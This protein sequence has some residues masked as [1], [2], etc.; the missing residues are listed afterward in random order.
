[1][2]N[3]NT[4]QIF[5]STGGDVV[6]DFPKSGLYKLNIVTN[7]QFKFNSKV[8]VPND[9]EAKK[10]ISVTQ[11]GDV[12]WSPDL[13][14]MFWYCSNLNIGATDIPNF[15]NV[16][17]MSSMFA[18]CSNLKTI[19]YINNWNVGNVTNMSYMFFKNSLFDESLSNWNVG[20]VTNMEAMLSFAS[21]FNQNLGNWN[22]SKVTTMRGM[23]RDASSFNQPLENWNVENVVDMYVMF[24]NA[25]SFNQPLNN[26]DVSKVT[27]MGG[28]FVNANKFNQPIGNWNVG[29][30]TSMEHLFSGATLFNQNIGNWNLK[31]INLISN[32]DGF[33]SLHNFLDSSGMDCQNYMKTLKGWSE[34]TNT[35]NNLNLGAGSVRYGLD[36]KTYRDLLVNTKGWNITGDSYS[37]NCN[38]SL[39]VSNVSKD[40][41]Q[42]YPNP[43]RDKLYIDLGWLDNKTSKIKIYNSIGSLVFY[44]NINSRNVSE[45]NLNHNFPVGVYNVIVSSEKRS[46][47]FKVIKK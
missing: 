3:S 20:N 18:E 35:P 29:N 30:V 27:N 41:V 40:E 25:K 37:T 9:P 22:V 8:T 38:S 31:S 19:P 26:W 32:Y 47:S 2:T 12:N 1:M 4:S 11:W 7:S 14:Q 45:I 39:A 28:M 34:N 16:T 10:L 44:R 23:F 36:G 5:Q 15:Q 24:Y 33:N 46:R 6:I 13:S 17:N 21:A 42:I 43:F